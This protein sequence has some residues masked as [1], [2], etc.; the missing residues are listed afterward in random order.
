MLQEERQQ[1][2]LNQ[3]IMHQKVITADLC[4][5]LKVSLDTVRRDLS[6]LE[7]QGRIKKVHG[8]A[9]SN[10]F[11]IPYQQQKV[12]A[13]EAKVEIAQKALK[14][15]KD[16]MYIMF[17]GGT[18]MV[19]LARII[20]RNFKGTF[21]TVSPLFALEMAQRSSV[22]VIL[23]GGKL[24]Q[25]SYICTGASVIAQLDE[26]RADL[27]FI[28]ANSISPK[29]G[30]TEPDWEIANVKKALIEA[31][32]KTAVLTVSEK[33]DTNARIRVCPT[34]SIDYLV[35]ELEPKNS[36]LSKYSK[37]IKNIW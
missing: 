24:S 9:I 30:L 31:S 17:G 25:N 8:G 37:S 4:K 21:F 14:L 28:G 20:P 6:E 12:Y 33:L 23:L 35:T 16:G 22:Q 7:K 3:I 29:T 32:D 26:I 27:C 2:I 11:H 13:R 19:E 34:G 5:L 10:S 1:I 15:V 36:R 18:V